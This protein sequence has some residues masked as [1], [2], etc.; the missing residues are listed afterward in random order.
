[1]HASLTS[2]HIARQFSALVRRRWI[3]SLALTVATLAVY[4]GFICVLA[5]RADLIAGAVSGRMTLGIPVG[6]GVIFA[7]WLVTGLYVRWAN[8]GYDA[9]VANL[10]NAMRENHG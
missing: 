1:M 3:V 4:Y 8:S 9:A 2:A 6:L 10:K 7:A 5:F